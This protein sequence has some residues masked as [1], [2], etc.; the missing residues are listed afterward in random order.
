M[1]NVNNPLELSNGVA[2]R[3]IGYTTMAG[4]IRVDHLDAPRYQFN[5]A[6]D[7]TMAGIGR[8]VLFAP[9]GD[10]EPFAGR[11]VTLRNKRIVLKNVR[12]S[13]VPMHE[14]SADE[15]GPPMEWGATLTFKAHPFISESEDERPSFMYGDLHP[16]D[17]E[18]SAEPKWNCCADLPPA[19]CPGFFEQGESNMEGPSGDPIAEGT[20]EAIQLVKELGSKGSWR[21]SR[22]EF[23]LRAMDIMAKLMPI[24]PEPAYAPPIDPDVALAR[25]LTAKAIRLSPN[26]GPFA[27]VDR[28]GNKVIQGSEYECADAFDRGEGDTT[29]RMLDAIALIRAGRQLERD[30]QSPYA[31]RQR[32]DKLTI[33][34]DGPQGSGVSTIAHYLTARMNYFFG[35]PTDALTNMDSVGGTFNAME[36]RF[37]DSREDTEYQVIDLSDTARD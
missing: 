2:V 1:I 15:D 23:R 13:F 35:K 31:E 18:P 27:Y 26:D 19:I 11:D 20:A 5:F 9:G 37:K 14:Y 28:D 10:V 21:W 3:F 34:V 17:L 4:R 32:P 36:A 22:R 16:A 6:D 7:G 8:H 12:M 25:E 29:C 30:S 24:E 33:T